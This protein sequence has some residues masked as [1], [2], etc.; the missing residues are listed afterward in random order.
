MDWSERAVR[1]LDQPTV[2]TDQTSQL[3][4][5]FPT[6]KLLPSRFQSSLMAFLIISEFSQRAIFGTEIVSTWYLSEG[7]ATSFFSLQQNS[8]KPSEAEGRWQTNTSFLLLYF[9]KHRESPPGI[10]EQWLNLCFV[11]LNFNH[12]KIDLCNLP[13]RRKVQQPGEDAATPQVQ[14]VA[15]PGH[16]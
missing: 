1:V 8:F 12:P 16:D 15:L 2:P 6:E 7:K 4:S 10:V 9:K 11:P 3:Q 14:N 13:P 5:G